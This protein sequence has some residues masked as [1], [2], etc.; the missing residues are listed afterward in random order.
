MW[1]NGT[2][3]QAN[4]HEDIF[5][6]SATK[7]VRAGESKKAERIIIVILLKSPDPGWDVLARVCGLCNRS[8]FLENQEHMKILDRSGS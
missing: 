5:D 2:I 6:P 8:S 4:I 7:R 3:H 1:Y